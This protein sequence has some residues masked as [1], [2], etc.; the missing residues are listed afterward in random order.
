[1]PADAAVRRR[2][3][4]RRIGGALRHVVRALG[5]WRWYELLGARLRARGALFSQHAEALAKFP[6][7]DK[8]Q[9]GPRLVHSAYLHVHQTHR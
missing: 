5:G 6:A 1:M 2:P 8:L 3:I 7:D 4:A 9:S